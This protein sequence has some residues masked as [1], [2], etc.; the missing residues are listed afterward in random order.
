MKNYCGFG[1][2]QIIKP[3]YWALFTADC[4]IHDSN[5]TLG[6][7]KEDRLNADL[8][9]FWRIL[10]DVNKVGDYKKKKRAIYIA[11]L[12]FLCVRLFGWASFNYK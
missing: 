1:H 11:I 10:S 9:F 4:E 2:S 8:G 6:G 5:Y 3:P 7:A 12:Y